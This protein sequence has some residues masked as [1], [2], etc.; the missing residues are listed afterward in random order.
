MKHFILYYVIGNL[1]SFFHIW[2]YRYSKYKSEPKKSD[3]WA[4]LVGVWL[5]PLQIILFLYQ[6]ATKSKIKQ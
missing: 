4:A 1:V 2:F 5:W 6:S 3:A